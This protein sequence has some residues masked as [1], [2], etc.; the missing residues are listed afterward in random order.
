MRETRN[1]LVLL[2]KPEGKKPFGRPQ[3]RRKENIKEAECGDAD[4]TRIR[5]TGRELPDLLSGC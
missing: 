1:E 2:Q 4:W 3:H 5:S